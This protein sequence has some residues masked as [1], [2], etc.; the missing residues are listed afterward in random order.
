LARK[1]AFGDE[2]SSSPSL[3]LISSAALASCAYNRLAQSAAP[4]RRFSP[5]SELRPATPA[6]LQVPGA[7]GI[8]FHGFLSIA[9]F[10]YNT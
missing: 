2:H 3:S 7:Q 1:L 4:V 8:R 5:S 6:R 9:L 10:T